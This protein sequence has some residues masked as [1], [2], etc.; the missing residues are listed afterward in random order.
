MIRRIHLQASGLALL[1]LTTGLALAQPGAAERRLAALGYSVAEIVEVVPDQ[2]V[3]S[4]AY[5]DQRNV[6]VHRDTTRHYLV[7][8]PDAC[9]ALETASLI[10]FNAAISGLGASTTL[11]VGA[12]PSAPECQVGSIFRL[13]RAAFSGREA[14]RPKST[15]SVPSPEPTP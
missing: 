4:W 12:S 6:L 2:I 14:P 15:P 7:T 9:P 8:L 5:L 11:K 3:T 1:G 13:D 10:A